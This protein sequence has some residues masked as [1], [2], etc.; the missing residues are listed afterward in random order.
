VRTLSKHPRDQRGSRRR[1]ADGHRADQEGGRH[2]RLTTP[3]A[4]VPQASVAHGP[5]TTSNGR[6]RWPAPLNVYLARA[7]ESY[8]VRALARCGG[9]V[10]RTA[11]LAH[12]PYGT[13]WK[14]L[15]RYGL[16]RPRRRDQP[17]DGA[18]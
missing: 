12:V 9:S 13:L 1:T 5:N 11:C 7:E 15:K 2:A 10:L 3:S 4:G 8:L 16:T 6:G 17:P 14:K 18:E